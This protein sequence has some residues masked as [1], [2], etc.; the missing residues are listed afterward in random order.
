LLFNGILI[1]IIFLEMSNSYRF[2]MIDGPVDRLFWI[3]NENPVLSG[4]YPVP[5]CGNFIGNLFLPFG[6]YAGI[7]TIN[8]WAGKF[9]FRLEL[10]PAAR[11]WFVMRRAAWGHQLANFDA[12]F[13]VGDLKHQ[14]Y[15]VGSDPV[16]LIPN[17]TTVIIEHM[18]RLREG[19]LNSV[20]IFNRQVS[21]KAI[22]AT[23]LNLR[24]YCDIKGF[25][26]IILFC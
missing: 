23:Q 22:Y 4:P 21:A 14:L 3:K 12:S 25:Y 11:E 16:C 13:S 26:F 2:D 19:S 15:I 9:P 20:I 7:G 10:A 5:V 17:E 8:D 18:H 6:H 24:Y 1:C